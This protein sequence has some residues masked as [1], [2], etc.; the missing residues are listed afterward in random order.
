MAA[1]VDSVTYTG[2]SAAL[3]KEFASNPLV[4]D[5]VQRTI[6]SGDVNSF[7]GL[8]AATTE[9]GLK[10]N[11]PETLMSAPSAVAAYE[12]IQVA[13]PTQAYLEAQ[14]L[15]H[16]KRLRENLLAASDSAD[17]V[18]RLAY[19]AIGRDAIA[20]IWQFVDLRDDSVAQYFSLVGSALDRPLSDLS[21]AKLKA[22]VDAA[23]AALGKKLDMLSR[24]TVRL[25]M[26]RRG[27][28]AM[29]E[30]SAEDAAAFENEDD[31]ENEEAER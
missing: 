4:R 22:L 8:R 16:L 30:M 18:E 14:R 9:M 6:G 15:P 21:S 10:L 31:D 2:T 17:P 20:R 3:S 27:V 26:L 12:E 29:P 7:K 28:F 11:A 13:Q 23:D 19:I 1:A 25:D 5:L 24:R